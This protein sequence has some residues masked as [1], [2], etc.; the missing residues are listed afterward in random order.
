M[1]EI[2]RFFGIIIRMFYDDHNPPY[3][4]AYYQG[5]QAVFDLCGN[6]TKGSLQ[7]KTA[8]KLV[9]EWVDLHLDEIEKDWNL[10]KE[11]KE[12]LKIEPLDQFMWNLNEIIELK[13]K[14]EYIYH[15]K[16]DNG[17]EGDLNFSSYLSRGN[18]FSC[19]SDKK[20]FS[21]AKIEGGTISWPNG[22][23][24]APETIY[25]KIHN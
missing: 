20:F 1:P 24:I 3:F 12:L 17:V 23:D 4:H 21:K 18:V 10:A 2:S 11:D 15:I 25:E 19:F 16:F 14:K 6:I 13:Y 7:S 22:V 8:T 9:R 5:N